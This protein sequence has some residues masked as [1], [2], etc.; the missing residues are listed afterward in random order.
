MPQQE[1]GNWAGNAMLMKNDVCFLVYLG[2][3]LS[4]IV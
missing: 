2:L 4:F 3:S 1:A